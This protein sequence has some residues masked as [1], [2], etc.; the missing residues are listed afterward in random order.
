MP[1][2]EYICLSC[3]ENY[4]FEDE[5]HCCSNCGERS[6]PACGGEVDTIEEY[7]EAMRINSRES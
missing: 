2:P 5:L 6:C 3:G 7:D 4:T 1:D